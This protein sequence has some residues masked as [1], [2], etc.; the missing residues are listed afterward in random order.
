M[1][2]YITKNSQNIF[3]LS[4]Q[5][6]G[7]ASNAVK[8]LTDN[9]SIAGITAQISAG[10]QIEYTPS[11]GGSVSDF[12]SDNNTFVTTGSGNPEQGRGFNLGFSLTGLR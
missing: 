9:P 10:T 5:L 1:A 4:N 2:K 8:I 7:N 6:Y 12:F 11:I 3:D